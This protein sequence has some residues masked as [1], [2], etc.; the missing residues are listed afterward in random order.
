M[1]AISGK[2]QLEIAV[3]REQKTNLQRS[4]DDVKVESRRLH[5]AL[6]S[7][8]VESEKRL[9]Q[10]E[11]ISNHLVQS[12]TL[13]AT[14]LEHELEEVKKTETTLRQQLAIADGELEESRKRLLDGQQPSSAHMEVV[15]VLERQVQELET[16]NGEL[17]RREK[18]IGAR[19]KAGALVRLPS[20][21]VDYLH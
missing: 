1:E 4:L 6:T 10:Q 20:S 17:A 2:L 8:A 7:S 16:M 19:Y 15:N 13:R 5:E 14:Y 12:E 18:T 11:T 21:W 9:S 3:L